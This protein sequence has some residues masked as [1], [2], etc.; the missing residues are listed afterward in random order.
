MQISVIHL[1][2]STLVLSCLVHRG[3]H[4]V[5]LEHLGLRLP[6]LIG[7]V[8]YAIIIHVSTLQYKELYTIKISQLTH[9]NIVS[10]PPMV[11]HSYSY[12][13]FA[14]CLQINGYAHFLW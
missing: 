5:S 11:P 3:Q 7:K 4:S 12:S 13:S 14:Q 2:L 8:Q 1:G 6:Y 10:C 9:A